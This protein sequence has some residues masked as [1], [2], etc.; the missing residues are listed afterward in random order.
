MTREII[1]MFM[2][3]DGDMIHKN[4]IEIGLENST[5]TDQAICN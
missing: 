3:I 5:Y 2:Y 1:S 4:I